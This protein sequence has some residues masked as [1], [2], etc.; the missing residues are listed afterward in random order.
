MWKI[1][2]PLLRLW[3]RLVLIMVPAVISL[4]FVSYWLTIVLI[5]YSR[6]LQFLGV[7]PLLV[8]SG[9]VFRSL[10]ASELKRMAEERARHIET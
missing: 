3:V 1:T 4:G 8:G 7:F 6:N 2:S 9:L 5:S 10:F